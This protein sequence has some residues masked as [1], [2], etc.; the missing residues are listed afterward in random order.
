MPLPEAVLHHA[1]TFALVILCAAFFVTV[2][3]II[4]GPTLADRVLGLDMLVT[5]A[6]GFIAVV[7][8]RTGLTL[9]VDIAIALGLVGFLSTVAFARFILQSK[10]GT[11][12]SGPA[13]GLASGS[14]SD[15]GG[16]AAGHGK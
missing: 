4:A 16:K 10:G 11:Q 12:T 9:Y 15:P 3:R 1:G 5:V 14:V 7:T 8:I 13:S 2:Y 6:I